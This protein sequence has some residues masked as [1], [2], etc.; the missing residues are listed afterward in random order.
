MMSR[1]LLITL[2]WCLALMPTI[3]NAA[4]GEDCASATT[5]ASLPYTDTGNTATAVDDYDEVCP[6][7]N[8]GAP[9]LVY[10]YTPTAN[11]TIDV[12]LC[13]GITN[14]DTKLYIYENTCPT[15]TSGTPFACNDDLCNNAPIYNSNFVSSLTGLNLTSGNTYYFVVDGYSSFSSGDYTLDIDIILADNVGVTDIIQPGDGCP[16]GAATVEV[17]V[18]NFGATSVSNIDMTLIVDGGTPLVET[19]AGPLAGFSTTTYTFTATAD[20]STVGTH[21]IQ[22]AAAGATDPLSADDSL[23]K[24]VDRSILN[25]YPYVENFDTF[26]TCNDFCQDGGCASAFTTPGWVNVIGDAEDWDVWNG[27]IFGTTITGDHTS[28]GG[29]FIVYQPNFNCFGSTYSMETPCFDIGALQYPGF[30]F[31]YFMEG[32]DPGQLKVEIN[33]GSGWVTQWSRSGTQPDGW[34]EA[35]VSFNGIAGTTVQIRFTAVNGNDFG[36]W[37][38]IDDFVMKNFVADAGPQALITPTEDNGCGL[39]AAEPVIVEVRNY[40]A[41]TIDSVELQ[42]IVDGTLIATELMTDTIAPLDT[43]N[44]TFTATANLA[45]AGTHT[46]DVVAYLKNNDPV[47]SNDTLSTTITKTVVS[48]YPYIEDFDLW[49]SC[50]SC[51]DG[52][53]VTSVATPGWKQGEGD[54]DDW[55]IDANGTSSFNTGPNAD[56][57]TGFGNYLYTETSGCNNNTVYLTTPCF[58]LTSLSAPGFFFWYHMLGA[59][60][61]DLAVEVNDGTGWTEVWR[62]SGAQ[63]GQW[64]QGKVALTAYLNQTIQLRFVGYTGTTFTSDMAIDDVEV[65]NIVGDDIATTKLITPSPA[66]TCQSLNAAETVTVELSNQGANAITSATLNLYLNSALVATETFTGN[67]PIGGSVQYTYTA[68]A[69]M[70]ASGSYLL[71]SEAVITNDTDTSNNF[72]RATITNYGA[73]VSAYPYMQTF[74]LWNLCATFGNCTNGG[75]PLPVID[76]WVNVDYDDDDWDMDNNNTSSLNTGPTFDHTTGFGNYLYTEASGCSNNEPIVETPCFDFTSLTVPEVSFWYHMWGATMGTMNLEVDT[77]GTGQ[78]HTVWTL[79]GDQGDQWSEAKV[80]LFGYGGTTAKFRFKGEVGTSFTSDMAIDDFGVRELPQFDASPTALVTPLSTDNCATLTNAEV[81]SVDLANLGASATDT[82]LISFSLDGAQ[83]ELDTYVVPIQ[84]NDTIL[85]TFDNTIDLSALGFYDVEVVATV[86]NGDEDTTNDTLSVEVANEGIIS[87]FPYHE[88]FDGFSLCANVGFACENG[89][90]DTAFT[91]LGWHNQSG[92]DDTEW[93]VANGPTPNFF[94]GPTADHTSG[95]GNYLY[96]DSWNCF[97]AVAHATTPCF[98]LGAINNPEASF[99]VFMDGQ[100]FFNQDTLRFQ[101]DTTG[102]GTWTDL[103]SVNTDNAGTLGNQWFLVEVPLFAY[104]G[105]TAKFRFHGFT[106]A[107]DVAIDDFRI[108]EV[109]SYDASPVALVAPDPILC[110]YSAAETVTVEVENVGADTASNFDMTLWVDGTFVATETWTNTILPDASANY[111]F[112]ATADLSLA[113]THTIKIA[114]Y[115]ANE[116]YTANDTTEFTVGES[117]IQ[118]Y[119]YVQTFDSLFSLCNSNCNDGQCGTAFNAPGWTNIQGGTEDDDWSV[120][121]GGTPS[122]NTGPNGDHTTGFGQYL[123]VET[124][125]C[126]NNTLTFETPCFDLSP[127]TAPSVSF[128]YHMFGA[129][130]GTLD[131]QIDAGSGYTSIWSLSGDQGNQW[132]QVRLPLLN[133]ANQVVRFRMVG[134]S[135]TTFT[136]DFA[137]DDFGVDELPPA[138]VAA[139]NFVSPQLVTGCEGLTATEQAIVNVANYGTVPATGFTLEVFVNGTSQGVDTVP[140]PIPAGDT[141]P[142]TF[143]NLLDLSAIGTYNLQAV[144]NI[145][146]DANNSD[147]S[148]FISGDNDGAS[149]ITNLPYIENFDSWNDCNSFCSDGSCAGLAF[150][151]TPGWKNASGDDSDWSIIDGATGST[152]TGPSGDH[153]TGNG[154]YIYTEASGCNSNDFYMQLPCFDFVNLFAPEISFWYHMW[155]GQMGTLAVEVDT[156]GVGNWIQVWSLTGD[157]GNQWNQASVNLS[158][159]NAITRIRF[160]GTTGTGFGSDMAVDDIRVRDVIPDDLA[161]TMTDGLMDGCGDPNEFVTVEVFNPGFNTQD[162]YT[163]TVQMTGAVSQTIDTVITA[164]LTTETYA[165]FVLGPFNT[166][167]GGTF[168]FNSF[169]TINNAVDLNSSNDNITDVIVTTALSDVF[170]TD[171]T[172]CGSGQVGLSVTGNATEYFWYNNQNGGTVINIGT[173]F[174][175]PVLTDTTAYWVEGR[176]WVSQKTAKRDTAGNGFAGGYNDFYFDGLRFNA[177]FDVTIDSV[178]LYPRLK[179]PG[180]PAVIRINLLDKNNVTINT[181]SMPFYGT[182]SDTTIAIDF[183]VPRGSDYQLTSAGSA[184]IEYYRNKG[185]A[186]Y[187]YLLESGISITGPVNFLPGYYYNFYN[188]HVTFLGCPSPRIPVTAIVTPSTLTT[189]YNATAPSSVGATD[190]TATVTASNGSTPYSYQWDANAGNQTTQTATNL[191]GSQTY[192]VTVTDAA[193]C[194]AEQTIELGASVST[195]PLASIKQLSVFPNPVRNMVNIDVEL[196]RSREIQIDIYDAIGQRVYSSEIVNG[197]KHIFTYDMSEQADGMYQIRIRVDDE[198]MTRS[199]IVADE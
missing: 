80:A 161:V 49:T 174:T 16:D 84:P 188:W 173:T 73:P 197:Q 7:N 33:D 177:L 44:Y 191:A 15:Y 41:I 110:S 146:G 35:N 181:V 72:V 143:S 162:D 31:W 190:G 178:T 142:I 128:W 22:A 34:H 106:T 150:V 113:G 47:A 95:S 141:L 58:D 102:T 2:C 59:A 90:C 153:T 23:T 122:F 78:W 179:N 185:G 17:E 117:L 164:P 63:G 65:K 133:Y 28:G 119:P 91:S 45:A 43:R 135:G 165:T 149:I 148:T 48:T 159:Y 176:N 118:T 25:A 199:V 123:F 82:V 76:G 40:G 81:V 167:G 66:G 168:N 46:V 88:S 18:S 55:D 125:G 70:A 111:T 29:N 160:V 158:G 121:S 75:C 103:W 8:A 86:L 120:G 147:N 195:I 126:N 180:V 145:N 54:D 4:G 170:G 56:H 11:E 53:C 154:N 13:T 51:N 129:A 116:E 132:Q 130:M 5:I 137:I 67:I 37:M 36:S 38:G 68:T 186:T 32:T 196:D 115:F 61:G 85:Y 198:Y 138:D 104:Q 24:V 94:G 3:L 189:T 194:T 6:F 136:S 50:I 87:T 175:T 42:L 124:S 151:T 184:D 97:N 27:Q 39:G 19:L 140:G 169:V 107:S 12:T 108:Y 155:G 21:T 26:N 20:L 187:P 112:T 71:E 60:M 127:L 77:S 166:S 163:V 183:F 92:F 172:V 134:T 10:K 182:V 192:S 139:I 14:Y 96:V 101:V 157:Q 171:G 99:W 89:T 105:S 64:L 93:F 79:S 1:Y 100:G 152:N 52:A 9:D 30:S 156:S 131:F 57:T 144:V 193:G 69:N 62:K 114:T 83:I 98:D 74:D 109:F